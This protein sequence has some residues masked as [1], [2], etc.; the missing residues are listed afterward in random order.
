MLDAIANLSCTPE[1][2]LIDAMKL[3]TPIPQTSIIKGDAKSISI[4]AASII[5]KVTRDR[6]MKELGE[7]YPAYGF[8]QHM[9]YGTKQH[10]EAIEAHGVFIAKSFAPIKDMIQ[11][12]LRKR[13]L[14]LFSHINITIFKKNKAI[15]VF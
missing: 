3:P 8:E 10:L 5:A 13:S 4:S 12:K 2:L 7:K 15:S 6:M 14:F 11:N 9:G 1:Y